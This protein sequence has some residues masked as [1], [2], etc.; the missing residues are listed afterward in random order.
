MVSGLFLRCC[1]MLCI[2][3]MVSAARGAERTKVQ[4]QDFDYLAKLARRLTEG[5]RP[6][7][8]REEFQRERELR[9]EEFLD[10]MGLKPLPD[11]TPLKV[12]WLGEPVDLG[13]CLLRKVVFHTLPNVITPSYLFLPKDA[14]GPVPAIIYV[15][16]SGGQSGYLHHSVM[17]AASGIAALALPQR[18]Q[19]GPIHGDNYHWYS[20]GHHP[21][22]V[23]IWDVVRAVDFLETL[24][25][26]I[27]AKRLG[28][29][30][31]SSGSYKTWYAATIEPRI[32]AAL[33]SQGANTAAG[34]VRSLR[35]NIKGDHTILHNCYLRDYQD[36]WALRAPL[37]LLHQHGTGDGMNSQA[38][39]VMDYIRRVYGTYEAPQDAA[40]QIFKQGH[41]DTVQL[42]RASHL[43]FDTV[44]R[45][46]VG[47]DGLADVTPEKAKQIL[48]GVD[49]SLPSL[50]GWDAEKKRQFPLIDYEAAFARPAPARKI[51]NRAEY[52]AF[53]EELTA[54]LRKKI[55]KRVYQ[56]GKT[57]YDRQ[58]AVLRLEDGQL[59][60]RMA[61]Y[62]A[63]PGP[64]PTAILLDMPK[65]GGEFPTDKAM[66]LK[67]ELSNAGLTVAILEPTGG[68]ALP[69]Q[70][71]QDGATGRQWQHPHLHRLAA[72]VGHTLCS[73]RILDAL[74]AVEQVSRLEAVDPKQ[75]YVWGSG[76]LA[77]P[78][79]YAAIVDA[80]VAG[81]VL[82]DPPDRHAPEDA[83]ETGLLHI[84]VHGDIPQ[85]AGLLYP[86]KCSIVR[87]KP[88]RWS[89]PRDLYRTLGQPESFIYLTPR[90]DVPPLHQIMPAV[91]AP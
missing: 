60:R 9:R 55:L 61:F 37:P 42:R 32:T 19:N 89:W 46:G 52:L 71:S 40:L 22:A 14:P 73:M 29:T 4:G 50:R 91:G 10:V 7:E 35:S 28:L 3:G 58:N 25:K 38:P 2:L 68:D 82:L 6:P 49:M 59:S 78:A 41:D 79:L 34:M 8:S 33:P 24:P 69:A 67:K 80:R 27:D 39:V 31:R 23:M 30:G 45:R 44:L 57:S 1:A 16:G 87:P 51:K 84:L 74:G 13:P 65:E 77:V 47:A 15:C 56:R 70:L 53:R 21:C 43:W 86:R 63:R 83:A 90:G 66:R 64:A 76:A 75:I 36:Y 72:V 18:P 5:V 17:Y 62:P 88:G 85:A 11:K 81:V 48:D 20:T 54:V 26:L 12:K